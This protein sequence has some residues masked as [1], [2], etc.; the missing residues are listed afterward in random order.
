MDGAIALG[1][2]VLPRAKDGADRAPQLIQRILREGGAGVLLDDLEEL[3]DQPPPIGGIEVGV[4]I[5]A[6]QVL[7]SLETIFEAPV[8]N[9][10]DDVAVHLDEAPVAI[11]G[12]ALIGT[13]GQALDR[14]VVEAQVQHGVHHAGHR[15]AGP[16][17][18]GDE[19]GLV[20]ISK[21]A[22]H[23]LLHLGQSGQY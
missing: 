11:E 8:R 22:S 5:H 7:Q 14:D 20:W 13:T 16:G 9:F 1:P 17:A 2:V 19:Q 18:H 15:D 12:E 3:P 23:H 6:A 10:E 21:P 4:E